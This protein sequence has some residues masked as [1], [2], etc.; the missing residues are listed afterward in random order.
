M[1]LNSQI[2]ADFE[3]NKRNLN[4]ERM[5]INTSNRT[6]W[7]TGNGKDFLKW[8]N[9]SEQDI[10]QNFNSQMFYHYDAEIDELVKKWLQNGDFKKIMQ[11]LHGSSSHIELPEDYISLKNRLSNVPD[12]V[13]FDLLREASELSQRSGLTGLLVLRNFALL[14]GYYFANLT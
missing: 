10:P 7:T 1:E 14:G 2:G 4:F 3:E 6:F 9:I 13:D 12:W 5:T 8:A 11:S